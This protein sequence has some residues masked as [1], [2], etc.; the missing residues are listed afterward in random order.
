MV[1]HRR[2]LAPIVSR[3]HYVQFDVSPGSD[4]TRRS[5]A[6]VHAVSD[7]TGVTNP[8]DVV[9]G[10]IIKAVFI[11]LW[12]KSQAPAGTEDKFQFAIEK[13]PAGAAPLS[14]TDMN[15]LQSYQNKKNILYF[16]QGVL[17]DLTV[18]SFPVSRQ[19][20]LIPKGK[21]RFGLDDDLTIALSTTGATNV[22]CGFATYKEYT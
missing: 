15:T 1:R 16:T 3:K 9:E 18:Q 6:V 17:G 21:Q 2:M 13:V 20:W 22:T 19:W 11:E 14:F 12:V 7:A 5:L 10:S 4:A 8:S